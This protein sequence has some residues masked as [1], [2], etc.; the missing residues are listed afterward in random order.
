[1]NK[2]PRSTPKMALPLVIVVVSRRR[3]LTRRNFMVAG[4]VA[5]RKER[6]LPE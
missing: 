2:D 6:R 3:L 5:V 4:G 1:M